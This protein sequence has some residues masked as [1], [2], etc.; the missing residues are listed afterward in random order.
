VEHVGLCLGF[1][2]EEDVRRG[3]VD[4]DRAK[5]VGVEP[6][7][8]LGRLLDEGAIEVGSRL[9]RKEEILGPTRPGRAVVVSG[10]TRPCRSLRELARGADLLIHEATF[11]SELSAE[12]LARGHSTAG[13]AA[14]TAVE[15]GV[16]RLALTHVSPRHQEFPEVLLRDARLVFPESILPED[17][18]TLDV[19]LPG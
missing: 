17:L 7:P 4:L 5:A 13:E 6:G 10:D 19:P 11:T 18:D 12:A 2:V 3:S 15:A 1:R 14:R 8:D 9:V 16:R